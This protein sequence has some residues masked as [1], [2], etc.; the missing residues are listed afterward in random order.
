MPVCLASAPKRD[1]WIDTTGEK[2]VLTDHKGNPHVLEPS[3]L[4][5]KIVQ[6][7]DEADLE[8]AVIRINCGRKPV[9]A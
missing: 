8:G 4:G 6:L 9:P 2:P 5:E 3:K 7:T 1:I